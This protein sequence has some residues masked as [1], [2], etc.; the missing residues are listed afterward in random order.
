[1]SAL[2]AGATHDHLAFSVSTL[3]EALSNNSLP[4]GFWIAGDEAYQ[5]SNFL[6]TPWP[7][8][9]VVGDSAKDAFK[10]YQ[11]SL[12]IHIEQSFGQ[13]VRRFGIL[14]K[15]LNFNIYS[16]CEVVHA[17]MSVHNFLIDA[18]EGSTNFD[19]TSLVQSVGGGDTEFEAWWS[20]EPGS[21][22]CL[23]ERRRDLESSGVRDDLT[24]YLRRRGDRRPS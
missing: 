6:L 21:G 15:P 11:S 3:F 7:S 8:S 14:W 2:T 22:G 10:F 1:M 16:V 9:V 5:C 17:C 18:N 19:T 4:R 12:R 20:R 13:L 23:W 24:E